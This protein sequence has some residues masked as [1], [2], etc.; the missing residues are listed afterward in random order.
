MKIDLVEPNK[1]CNV[2][3]KRLT[4]RWKCRV[5]DEYSCS[6]KCRDKHMEEMDKV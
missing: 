2:C 4:I 3:G 6:E 1:H 5:C